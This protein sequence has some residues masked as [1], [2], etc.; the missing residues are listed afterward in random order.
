MK[1]RLLLIVT[2]VTNA[3]F[4][5]NFH[6]TQGKLDISSSG[7]ATYTLPIALPPS[8]KDVGPIINLVYTSGQNGGIAG[9]G[10]NINSITNIARISTRKDIDGFRDGVDFDADDKLA[11]DGQR[12]LLKPNTGA[13]WSDGSQYETEVQSNTKV[14]LKGSGS[15]MYFI[16]T[17]P[18]GSRA[19]YGN[20][21]GAA[22]SDLTAYYIVR[23]EDTNGNFINYNYTK[24]YS[25]SLCIT[26]I[27]FSGNTTTN[28]TALNK[29][30][31]TYKLAAQ[32]ESAYIKGVKI[33]KVEIL[34]KVEVFTNNLLF[35]KYQL[36]HVADGLGYQRVSQLQEF[37][38]AGEGANPIQ[39]NY[40]TT[41]NDVTENVTAFTNYLDPT[42]PPEMSGDFDGDGNVDF[43]SNNQVYTKL[44]QGT[45]GNVCSLPFSSPTRQKMTA[46]T[47]SNNKVNQKQSIVYADE[48]ITNIAFKVHNLNNSNAV[49]LDYTKN[50]PFDNASNYV[51]GCEF[52]PQTTPSPSPTVKYSNQYLEGDF[53]GDGLSEVLIL[54][55]N[56]Y[57]FYGEAATGGKTGNPDPNP[58]VLTHVIEPGYKE[59]RLIDLNPNVSNTINTSGN[60]SLGNPNL[61]LDGDKRIVMDMNSDGKADVFV[62]NNNGSYKIVS[63]KQLTVSPWVEME[64]IGQGTIDAYSP[65]KQMLFGDYNGDGK[66]DIMLPDADGNGCDTCSTWHIYY[67]N[68]NPAG[69]VYFAKESFNIAPYRPSTGS[70]YATQVQTSS[71]FAMDVNKDGKSDLVRVWT[72]VWQ[73]HPFWDPKDLDTSWTVATYIN[74][75]GYNGGFTYDYTSPSTHDNDD[76]SRPIA[77]GSSLK[78]P[79]MDSDLLIIRYH[80]GTSYDKTVTYVD[81]KKDYS[82][83]NLITKV[84][85]SGGAI[86]DDITYSDMVPSDGTN[87]YGTLNG[88]Y[89]S[90]DELEYPL[91]ELKQLSSNKLVSQLKNTSLG[92]VKKQDFKYRGLS[93][94][95]NG[96]G[97]LGF[98]GSA[99]SSWFKNDSDKRIWSLVETKPTQRGAIV[100]TWNQL[101]NSSN[102]AFETGYTSGLLSKTENTY[103]E[104]PANTFPYYILLNTQTATDY[105]TNVVSQKVYNSYSTDYLLPLSVTMNNL[106]G[107]TLQGST[108]TVTSYDNVTSGTGSGY[109]IGRPNEVNTTSTVYVNTVGSSDIKTSKEKY[110]YTN[111][112]VTRT[113]KTANGSTETLIEKF[114]YFPNGLLQKKTIS[115]TGFTGSA[116][117]SD[118]S[119]SYTYDTTN[120][121]V[122]TI[123]DPELLVTTNL[124]YDS[125]Y[126]VVLTQQNPFGQVTTSVYDTWGKRTKVTDFLG[127]SVNYTYA[128][129]NNIYTTTQTG[130]DGSSS[131]VDSDALARIIRK[132]SKNVNGDWVYVNTEYDYLGKKIRDSEPYFSTGSPTQWTTY[133]YDDYSRPI[134]T[135]AF[136]GK[137]INT[138]YTGLTVNVNDGTMVKEKTNNANGLVI[139]ATDSPGGTITYKYDARGNLLISD[140]AGVTIEMQYDNWGRKKKLIDSSAGTY[141]YLYNA[142]GETI[143]ESTPKGITT[144]DIDAVGK[145]SKKT[146]LAYSPGTTNVDVNSTNT[147]ITSVYTY[148]VTNKWVTKIAVTN[149]VDGNSTYDYSYDATTKQ[150][151]K[152]IETLPYATFTKELT[153]DV[154][155]RVNTEKL[156]ASAHSKS[157]SKTITH[158]YKNGAEWQMQDGTVM[159]WQANTVNA[160]GQLTGASLGNGIEI[161]N[162][163]DAYGYVSQNKHL[164]S[165]TNVMTLDNVFEPVLGNL[166]SRYN[167]MFDVKENFT[168]DSLDRLVAWEGNSQN[169]LTLPFNTTTEGFTFTGT[170]TEG[171][172][173]NVTGTMK[174]ILKN[175]F[176]A[177]KKPLTTFT[178][179]PGNKLRVKAD[180]TNKTGTTGVIVDAVMVETD[181]LD[182]SNYVE[183]P[184]GT[185]NNGAFDATYTASNF[186]SNPKFTLKF[187]VDEESPLGSNGGGSTPP[188]TTFYI[189]NLKIDALPV[190]SQTYDDRG[191]ITN[192]ALGQ[193]QYTNAASPY[194][195]TSVLTTADANTYYGA[196]PLQTISYNVFKAPLQ[197]EDQ[198]VDKISFGYNAMQQ[199]NI[200]YYGNTNTDKLTRPYRQYYSGDG[201]M[202]IKATFAA[203]NTTT[204]TSVEF[205]TY[206]GGDAYSAPMLV[207]SDGT[208]QNYFYLH[209]DYQGSIMAVT[210]A[211]GAVIEK[212]LFDPWGAIAKVQDGAGNN[213]NKLTFFDR[214]YTGHQHLEGVGL[215]HMNGRLYDPKLHRFLQPDNYVQDQYNTQNFNRYSYCLNNPLK[216]NDRSGEEFTMLGAA[217]AAATIAVISYLTSCAIN[218]TAITFPGLA[219]N[220]VVGSVSG[221]VTYGIGSATS[222]I[223]NFWVRAGVE[224]LAHGLFQG[225]MYSI[226]GSNFWNGF[227]SG[228]ISSIASS[229]WAGGSSYDTDGNSIAGSGFGGIAGN[230][231]ASMIVFGTI[232]GGAAAALTGGNFWQGAVTGLVVSG[233]NHFMHSDPNKR[234]VRKINKELR[235]KYGNINDPAPTGQETIDDIMSTPT[236][237]N[238]HHNS[239][240]SRFT[241]DDNFVSNAGGCSPESGQDAYTTTSANCSGEYYTGSKD[242]FTIVYRN[243]F[244]SYKYLAGTIV[245]E[246]GHCYSRYTGLMAKNYS[247]MRNNWTKTMALDEV[248][249]YSFAD[250]FGFS[251]YQGNSSYYISG[252]QSA[253]NILGI[254]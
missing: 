120:R 132:G 182:A 151:N 187:V 96:I 3:L 121:F 119:T 141:D 110:F 178:I 117:A 37:N 64:I 143:S 66:P 14:E 175:T 246:L 198:G 50:I 54:A 81:F 9:Q 36:T 86:V 128:R 92:V 91:V 15:T 165:S 181:P 106:L 146:V 223:G 125:L 46:I 5:Q 189:D 83:D 204:P 196:K 244:Q 192:N 30:V 48:T 249:A 62:V 88:F 213:L 193:Y 172:V 186:V 107:T 32:K 42:T 208:T 136:T 7:Q 63:F 4:S 35:R 33:E 222:T 233:L 252:L 1:L 82:Q 108:T 40:N 218:H 230:S 138:T 251:F 237:N 163:Y 21:A 139:S 180:I 250:Q 78:F 13:Y 95:L 228:S 49:V 68:P 56:E 75:I 104:S 216:Y 147:N 219:Y 202:E 150:L 130:D 131:I 87:G 234:L 51:Y 191:K 242:M 231:G 12:L 197:I 38:G 79:G 10:W 154:F 39:F 207:K 211:A 173:T 70:D 114:D 135:T 164:L 69:G 243:S 227:A 115:A 210:N 239:G 25:K 102:F 99:R 153:F 221:A 44:F 145:V 29:I 176:V 100:R 72:N 8:I 209:R 166:M 27:D 253:L 118:R 45:A 248:F 60:C 171:S 144:Y 214:G 105:L 57:D 53:N 169:V 90:G 245:H 2:L 126:G 26:Q 177:A 148:D 43:I 6:D 229:M 179:T 16:V 190:Y 133:E 188:N 226:T 157:S 220:V 89:S 58:C 236:L 159:K 124:T 174:V 123:T 212:R 200:M 73:Y 232:S 158:V 142:F 17:S 235:A 31:F 206:I 19:W 215:V 161:T 24:P 94:N 80:T 160:R 18:D 225:S 217:V 247:L 20:Y 152:T 184:F 67:S 28:P 205:I 183:I 22:A 168:Y 93:F 98:K 116:A 238:M 111:G 167:S 59:V 76:N 155:G 112:N 137:V 134:K 185:V 65:T 224:A 61:Y 241:Y 74:T 41:P 11:L 97:A 84:T 194:Q 140:Y 71:Y 156:T 101:L 203:G 85:Q 254:K 47:L 127:K 77:L 55:R 52:Q 103:T 240:N 34:D 201:T 199:R 149:P 129:A 170:A 113:E 195:N 23:Y 109:Y 122:K 162:T